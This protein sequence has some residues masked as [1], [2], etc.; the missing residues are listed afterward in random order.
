M[1][2]IRDKIVKALMR[3]D[4]EYDVEIE[5]EDDVAPEGQFSEHE[6]VAWIRDQLASGNEYAWC[7]VTVIARWGSFEG[8]TA[9]GGCSYASREALLAMVESDMYPEALSD[10]ATAIERS[11]RQITQLLA[12]GK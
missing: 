8:S 2:N 9:L 6:D 10:L 3:V 11:Y 12:S 4:V 5:H 1:K 7:R